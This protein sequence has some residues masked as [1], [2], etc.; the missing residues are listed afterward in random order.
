MWRYGKCKY[1][2]VLFIYNYAKKIQAM[3]TSI[4]RYVQKKAW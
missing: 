2:F 4:A 3:I 1:V